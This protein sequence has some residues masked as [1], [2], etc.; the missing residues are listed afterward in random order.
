MFDTGGY[1]M[2]RAKRM[3][4]FSSVQVGGNIIKKMTCC[5]RQHGSILIGLIITM[6]VMAFLA[7]GMMYVTTTSAFQELLAN[8]NARAYYA[9]ESGGR[10]ACSLARG[11]LAHGSPPFPSLTNLNTLFSGNGTTYTMANGDTIQ[12]KNWQQLGTT[13]LYF[14]FDAVGIVGS[15]FLQAKRQLSFKIYPANQQAGTGGPSGPPA[16]PQILSDFDIPKADLDKFF[17][18][19]AS[20]EEDIKSTQWV[21]GDNALNLKSSFWTIG[22]DWWHN[23]D[24][25]QLDAVRI[26]NEGLLNYGVQ[27]KILIDAKSVNGNTLSDYNI[28]GISFRLDDTS[29]TLFYYDNMYAMSFFKIKEDSTRSTPDWYSTEAPNS[30]NLLATD[31]NWLDRSYSGTA[32]SDGEWYVVLWKRAGPTGSSRYPLSKASDDVKLT[33]QMPHTLLAYKKL[34]LS[35]TDTVLYY[36]S[37][38][39]TVKPQPWSTIVVYVNEKTDGTNRW[40]EISGYIASPSSYPRR[41]EANKTTQSILWPESDGLPNSTVG[42]IFQPITWNVVSGSGAA[43]KSGSSNKI[44]EDSS[45][46]TLNYN[47]YTSTTDPRAR[48]IGLHVYY[49][50]T[51]AQNQFYDNFYVDLSPSGYG[52]YVDGSGVVVQYP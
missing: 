42:T 34:S 45:F 1:K 31:S 2:L 20:S 30:A 12:I 44:I 38:S 50:S 43:A 7:A 18:P 16:I 39:Q 33:K 49:D 9:A 4:T 32:S 5:S 15:G 19:Y 40:N 23:S 11:T 48:E 22:L 28:S 25:A 46:N 41:T 3:I 52:G 37:E 36:D 21:G 29:S 8:N 51:S 47:M 26:D 27:V 24:V 17:N 14:T 13:S 10:Y 6:V 35:D